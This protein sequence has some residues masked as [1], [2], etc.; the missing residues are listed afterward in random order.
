M[1][2]IIYKRRNLF[3]TYSVR[4]DICDHQGGKYDRKSADNGVEGES[5]K[6]KIEGR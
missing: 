3:W 6:H 1:T 5:H 2:K 4:G